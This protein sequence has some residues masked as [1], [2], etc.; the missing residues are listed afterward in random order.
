MHFL[1]KPGNKPWFILFLSDPCG[2]C[3]CIWQ[4]VP[5]VEQRGNWRQTCLYISLCQ[6]HRRVALAV[7][8]IATAGGVAHPED[9]L[10]F[11]LSRCKRSSLTPTHHPDTPTPAV[12]MW[13]SL[14][15]SPKVWSQTVLPWFSFN[16]A[17]HFLVSQVQFGTSAAG[18]ARFFLFIGFLLV[19]RK[20]SSHG[21]LVE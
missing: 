13:V 8:I 2:R 1:R 18:R 16:L 7:W 14:A 19:T 21:T 9:L 10:G 4:P 5:A 12:Q 6:C 3:L 20:K 15:M 17:F 11:G